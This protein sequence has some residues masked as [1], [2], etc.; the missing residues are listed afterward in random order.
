VEP[1][2]FKPFLFQKGRD[3]GYPEEDGF[4]AQM[5]VKGNEKHHWVSHLLL[6][7]EEL[8]ETPFP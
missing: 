2:D 7:L 5:A 6:L 4:L 1:S 8:F 3:G